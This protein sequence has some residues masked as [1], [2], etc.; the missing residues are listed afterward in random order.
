MISWKILL[1]A[2]V[3]IGNEPEEVTFSVNDAFNGF[4]QLDKKI[5]QYEGKKAV[6]YGRGIRERSKLPG[7]QLINIWISELSI[8]SS[9][10]SCCIHGGRKF[11]TKGEG[12][13]ATQ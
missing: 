2:T 13:R 7:N 5:K 8:M 11:H 10:S 6:N 9:L 12:K 4:D 3:T 1:L